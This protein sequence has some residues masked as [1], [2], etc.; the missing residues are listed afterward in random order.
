MRQQMRLCLVVFSGTLLALVGDG[1]SGAERP[2]REWAPAVTQPDRIVGLDWSPDGG[3]LAT[4]SSNGPRVSIWDAQTGRL[5]QTTFGANMALNSSPVFSWDGKRVLGH[6]GNVNKTMVW[7]ATTG[8]HVRTFLDYKVGVSAG[9]LNEDGTVALLAGGPGAVVWD[10]TTGEVTKTIPVGKAPRSVALSADGKCGIVGMNDGTAAVLDLTEGKVLHTLKGHANQVRCVHLSRDGKRAVTGAEDKNVIVWNAETGEKV[11]TLTDE[12]V[13]YAEGV[14]AS[15]DGKVVIANTSL[16]LSVWDGETGKLIRRQQVGGFI[17]RAR[18]NP[19]G[20][21]I[22]L[23]NEGRVVVLDAK[24]GERDPI[25]FGTVSPVLSV[26]WHPQD[27]ALA[28]GSEAPAP[29]VWGVKADG[30][31]TVG[32]AGPCRVLGWDRAGKQLYMGTEGG[33]VALYDVASPEKP[34]TFKPDGFTPSGA[35]LAGDGKL[36]IAVD[37]K[38]ITLWDTVKNERL[39]SL[40][41][42][43]YFLRHVRWSPDGSHLLGANQ[44]EIILWETTKWERVRSLPVRFGWPAQAEWSHDGGRIAACYG[45]FDDPYLY[46]WDAQTGK[47]L[48]TIEAETGPFTSVCWNPDSTRLAVGSSDGSVLLFDADSRKQ[49]A[50][51]KG[52]AGRVAQ[53][54]WSH[55]G[56]WL[57]S[58]SYDGSTRLWDAATGQELCVLVSFLGGAE[59]LALAPDGRYDGTE[60]GLQQQL[61]RKPGTSDLL[62][63]E[64]Y[65]LKKT[66]GLLKQLLAR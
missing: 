21:K 25:V 53:V 63:P 18:L 4:T 15:A 54:T 2:G 38:T 55:N 59:W 23:G 33:N 7:D 37:Q 20:T 60:K 14:Q 24:T 61:Y 47:R 46:V 40:D 5:L 19:E 39:K 64:T 50:H 27:E 45:S 8:G 22:A 30:V 66:P 1:S 58:G 36:A 42:G 35:S 48:R 41:T 31:K 56:K 11:R 3:K 26:A 34:R 44:N 43:D 62:A 57:A 9:S 32:A 65:L 13:N 49:L 17:T 52:H 12:G 10:V 51:L 6:A 29:V 28:V 16:L